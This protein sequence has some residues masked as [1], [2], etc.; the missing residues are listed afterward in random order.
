M[1]KF[2]IGVL[3]SLLLLSSCSPPI[4]PSSIP[5][6]VNTNTPWLTFT[7]SPIPSMTPTAVQFLQ[8]AKS[9]LFTFDAMTKVA[10][11]DGTTGIWV[12]GDH[13]FTAFKPSLGSTKRIDSS[14]SANLYDV[15]FI[16]QDN[17][18]AV[19]ADGL[20]IH[21]NGNNWEVSKPGAGSGGPYFYDLY[22]VA[23]SEANNG[24]AAGGIKSEGGCQFLIYHWDGST[25]AEISLPEAWK[26]LGCVHDMAVLSSTDVWITGTNNNLQGTEKGVIIHWDGSNWTMISVL[27]SYNIYSLSALSSDNIWAITADGIILNW[28]G[29]KWNEKTQLDSANIIYARTSDDVFAVGD[30]IWHWNG[31]IWLEISLNANLPADTSIKSVIEASV[32]EGGNPI[33]YLLDSSGVLYWF[34]YDKF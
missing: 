25:W 14:E 20:I 15:D 24:W 22:S 32:D 17:G 19:G 33:M 3:L 10:L 1:K 8:V 7:P 29:V 30:K 27:S 31:N 9:P 34:T 16:S 6:A 5:V 4:T 26:L 2:P 12:V 18:W 21:W 11:P 23:F 13:G 28:D